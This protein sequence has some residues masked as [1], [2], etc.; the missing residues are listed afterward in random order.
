MF[1]MHQKVI[2]PSTISAYKEAYSLVLRLKW[3]SATELKKN[4]QTLYLRIHTF[5][6]YITVRWANSETSLQ[7]WKHSPS[8]AGSDVAMDWV[9]A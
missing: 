5:I 9:A 2:W 4:E 6:H 7:V 8:K 3:S 1:V